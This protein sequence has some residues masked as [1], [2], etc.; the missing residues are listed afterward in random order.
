M[1]SSLTL[2]G[3]KRASLRWIPF[4]HAGPHW[5]SGAR[6][7]PET[8]RAPS[9]TV[10][11]RQMALMSGPDRKG[12]IQSRVGTDNAHDNPCLASQCTGGL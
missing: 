7:K 3:K 11:P 9:E 8:K 10:G 2:P 12:V 5:L 4:W 1:I 6:R